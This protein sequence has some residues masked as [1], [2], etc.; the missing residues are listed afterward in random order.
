MIATRLGR[1]MSPLF[2]R[3]VFAYLGTKSAG[4]SSHTPSTFFGRTKSARR[5]RRSTI[6]S[7][8]TGASRPPS[9]TRTIASFN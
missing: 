1:P 4:R 8:S 3:R 7:G 5:C 6:H 9:V 2:A